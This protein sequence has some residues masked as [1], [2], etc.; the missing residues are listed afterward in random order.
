MPR[1]LS[2]DSQGQLLIK[3]VRETATLRGRSGATPSQTLQ[4]KAGA[5][6]RTVTIGL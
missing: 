1:E 2:L 4:V 6:A 3:P 5:A